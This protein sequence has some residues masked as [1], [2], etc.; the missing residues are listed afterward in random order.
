MQGSPTKLGLPFSCHPADYGGYRKTWH[1]ISSMNALNLPAY[2][3]LGTQQG[4]HDLHFF[5]ETVSPPGGSTGRAR[6]HQ[7]DS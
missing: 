5:L 6:K 2:V 4:E 3:V 7:H 1:E